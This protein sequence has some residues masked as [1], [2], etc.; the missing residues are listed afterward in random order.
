MIPVGDAGQ[1][2][3]LEVREDRVEVFPVLGGMRGKRVANLAGARARQHRKALGVF[4]VVGDPVGEA[5]GLRAEVLQF[6]NLGI[7]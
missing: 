1:D 4:E 3:P 2:D 5:M 7:G 6:G